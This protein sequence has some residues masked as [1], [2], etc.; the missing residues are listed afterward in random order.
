[1]IF[2]LSLDKKKIIIIS[3]R[4]CGWGGSNRIL[5]SSQRW[6]VGL[7]QTM[8]LR[9][10]A[11]CLSHSVETRMATCG[12]ILC[13]LWLDR[14]LHK[15]LVASHGRCWNALPFP[16]SISSVSTLEADCLWAVVTYI[17]WH[18]KSKPH[19]SESLRFVCGASL[20]RQANPVTFPV[21]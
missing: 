5:R 10:I 17:H 15:E 3:S 18:L 9:V 19:T 11:G 21:F 8:A 14:S 2:F 12:N 13:E 20:Q 1:M 4:W 16:V 7:L 6:R